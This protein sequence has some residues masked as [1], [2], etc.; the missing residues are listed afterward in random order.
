MAYYLDNFLLTEIFENLIPHLSPFLISP[1][2]RNKLSSITGLFPANLNIYCTGFEI[3]LSTGKWADVA[4]NI[5]VDLL[6]LDQFH[7]LSLFGKDWKSLTT[8]FQ[9]HNINNIWLEMDVGSQSTWPP[10]PN[11]F[12]ATSY[13]NRNNLQ[14]IDEIFSEL[15]ERSLSLKEQ[16]IIRKILD[17]DFKI[18]NL[19]FMLAR[20]LNGIRLSFQNSSLLPVKTYIDFLSELGSFNF[21][22]EDIEFLERAWPLLKKTAFNIDIDDHGIFPKIG[23]EFRPIW[24]KQ[25]CSNLL[26]FLISEGLA[27]HKKKEPLMAWFGEELYDFKFLPYKFSH[28]NNDEA[29]FISRGFSH[30]KVTFSPS[31]N[32]TAKIYLKAFKARYKK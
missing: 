1:E 21:R 23:W 22:N 5:P 6:N 19:G 10:L 20:P 29:N 32:P 28:S 4:F 15:K 25:D 17:F 27:K 12:L 9:N 30:I 18:F 8:F 31:E 11:L 2:C 13:T 26:D 3:P 7:S 24:L 16:K 14:N